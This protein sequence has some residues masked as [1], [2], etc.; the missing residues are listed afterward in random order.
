MIKAEFELWKDIE[1][2]EG[3]Y[4]VS[5]WARVKRLP[6]I[7]TINRIRKEKIMKPSYD[8]DGYLFIGLTI[9]G[10]QKHFRI[11]R[12]VAKAFIPN[13]D[14][15]PL[16]NHKDEV[17]DNNYPYNLEWCTYK[18]NTN[19]GNCISK[20]TKTW[21]ENFEYEKVYQYDLNGNFIKEWASAKEASIELNISKNG[22]Q[23][24]CYNPVRNK[25]YKG[26]I[27]S[28][29]YFEKIDIDKYLPKKY[30]KNNKNSKKVYQYDKDYNLIKI[31]ASAA[32]CY[33]NGFSGVPA[34]CRGKYKTHKGYIWSYTEIN[35]ELV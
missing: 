26:F 17:K 25:T 28:Y 10:K 4:Q 24:N 3:L 29:E 21:I 35:Q 23:S 22:I 14:N 30:I 7:D 33:R 34:C 16:V 20:R 12:L 31:W 11:H 13:P 15:L 19:Y 32:E 18:Y 27:W 6:T 5:T 2:F 9:N 1:G 8:K